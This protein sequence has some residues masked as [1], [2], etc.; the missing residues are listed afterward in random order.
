[1]AESENKKNSWR[2][3]YKFS[4]TNNATF[5]EVWRVR[6]TKY[7]AFILIL[8][9][10][11]F[12]IAATSVLIAF[13]NLRELI[14]GYPSTATRHKIILNEFRLDSLNREIE[15]IDRYIAN[16]SAIMQG[17]PP[18]EIVAQYDS[19]IDYS[20]IRFN[21]SSTDSALR[22]KIEKEDQFNLT[23]GL[24][25]NETVNGLSNLHFFPP[26]RG[27]IISSRFDIRTKHF[28]AD[29]ITKPKVLVS[30]ALDGV[31]IFTGWTMETGYVIHIQ[32]ANNIVTIYKHNAILLKE[33][34]DIVRAGEP[35][36]VVGDSGE[37]YTSG[38]HLHFEIWYKGSPLD[39]E[40]HV[41]F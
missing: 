24:T 12:I 21:Y 28:G 16:I 40:K 13:T 32:H 35:I 26:V 39:P 29:I 4:V 31:I 19:T 20:S 34:G 10:V 15:K 6:L 41:I 17:K 25:D 37:I 11:S 8:L 14:P 5:E 3:K 7:S 2:E 1:M 38:P 27:G 30:A 22:A 18:S 23:L 33:A 36:S 9:F